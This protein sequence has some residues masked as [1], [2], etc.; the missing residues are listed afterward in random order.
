[1]SYTIVT[2]K[3][4]LILHPHSP[5]YTIVNNKIFASTQSPIVNSQSLIVELLGECEAPRPATPIWALTEH[6]DAESCVELSTL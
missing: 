6:T 5:I 3:N 2:Y 1:M 4:Y